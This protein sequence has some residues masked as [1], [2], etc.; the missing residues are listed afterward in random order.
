M[1]ANKKKE[2]AKDWKDNSIGKL[3]ISS[4]QVKRVSYGY[5]FL[6]KMYHLKKFKKLHIFIANISKISMKSPYVVH[7]L[8]LRSS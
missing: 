1:A 2:K 8:K 5:S 7:W 6:E 3:L 4:S